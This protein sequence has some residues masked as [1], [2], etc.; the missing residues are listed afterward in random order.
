[1]TKLC[2]PLQQDGSECTDETGKV[3]KQ[4][5]NPFIEPQQTQ[6]VVDM[7]GL[8]IGI[9]G[10]GDG[11]WNSNPPFNWLLADVMVLNDII[12]QAAGRHSRASDRGGKLGESFC[13]QRMVFSVLFGVRMLH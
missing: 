5:D 4:P 9:V 12:E 7:K 11:G 8:L 13:L 6:T 1:M 2:L 10:H 3:I